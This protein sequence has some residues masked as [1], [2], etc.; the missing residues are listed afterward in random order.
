MERRWGPLQAYREDTLTT[1]DALSTRLAALETKWNEARTK[2]K[3]H[4][5]SMADFKIDIGDFLDKIIGDENGLLKQANCLFMRGN[6]ERVTTA[7][8]L[9]L[10]PHFFMMS[11]II[12]FTGVFASCC[13]CCS[14]CL[15]WKY[16]GVSNEKKKLE[17]EMAEREAASAKYM[18]VQPPSTTSQIQDLQS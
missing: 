11:I 10:L 17:K 18:Q 13:M 2:I 7:M 12:G 8:C 6:V 5:I 1:T 15:N 9:S 4:V 14:F 16:S 3:D